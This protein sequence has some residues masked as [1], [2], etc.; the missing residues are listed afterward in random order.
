MFG[1]VSIACFTL[2]YI[3]MFSDS[4]LSMPLMKQSTRK[5]RRKYLTRIQM[6]TPRRKKKTGMMKKLRIN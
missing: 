4:I 6:S 5:S 3:K 1:Y 2:I